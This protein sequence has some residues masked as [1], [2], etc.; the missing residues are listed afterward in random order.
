MTPVEQLE[1]AIRALITAIMLVAGTPAVPTPAPT[2]PPAPQALVQQSDFVYQGSF[3]LPRMDDLQYGG[4]S[5]TMHDDKLFVQA[6]RSST[7]YDFTIPVPVNSSVYSELPFA[8]LSQ[9]YFNIDNGLRFDQNPQDTMVRGVMFD[10]P[11]L[12]MSIASYYDAAYSQTRSHL[13]RDWTSGQVTSYGLTP[14]GHTA[15]FMTPA[16]G[17]LGPALTGNFGLPIITRESWGPAAFVF[18][19]NDLTKPAI[20]VLDYPN[21]E[22]SLGPWDQKSDV[23]N[24]RSAFGGMHLIGRSLLFTGVHGIGDFCYGPTIGD[25]G[26]CYDPEGGG[27]GN[28]SYPYVYRIWAYDTDDLV[29][30]KNGLKQPWEP[31]PYGVWNITLPMTSGWTRLASAY[32]PTTHRL[33]LLQGFGDHDAAY[34]FP[35]VHVY[36]VNVP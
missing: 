30:V 19:P 8:A 25:G 11:K 18:D 31:Q 1:A 26:P 34:G 13:S 16:T 6:F 22:H 9:T 35:V 28:H 23:W 20:P 3:R 4:Q 2:P 27:S 15:G 29:A 24:V 5:A 14:V 21:I 12:I 10:G 33:Y 36:A 32:D 17:A 7:F